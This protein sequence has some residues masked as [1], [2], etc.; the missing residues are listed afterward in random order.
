MKE[1]SQPG[2]ADAMADCACFIA[3]ET[4]ITLREIQEMEISAFFVLVDYLAKKAEREK[5]EM[6]K[7]KGKGKGKKK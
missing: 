1:R 2:I 4:S 7:A 6:E 5:A 3:T